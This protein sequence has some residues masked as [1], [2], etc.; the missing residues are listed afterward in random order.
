MWGVG[1]GD[2]RACVDRGDVVG[3]MGSYVYSGKRSTTVSQ[4]KME[5]V[6]G[7]KLTAIACAVFS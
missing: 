5:V 7:Q 2:G 6:G 4:N 3:L 1:G